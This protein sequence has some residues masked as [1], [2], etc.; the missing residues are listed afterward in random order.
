MKTWLNKQINNTIVN[1]IRSYFEKK[2]ALTQEQ[3]NLLL[4]DA[5]YENYLEAD[6]IITEQVDYQNKLYF[7]LRG[8]VLVKTYQPDG[9]FFCELYTKDEYFPETLEMQERFFGQHDAI[10][11]KDTVVLF[12]SLQKIN[13]L[14]TQNVQ[15]MNY[16][17]HSFVKKQM[18]LR[19]LEYACSRGKCNKRVSVVLDLF[20]KKCGYML[21]SGDILLPKALTHLVLESYCKSGHTII[22]LVLRDLRQKGFLKNDTQRLIL[23]GQML[24]K[25]RKSLSAQL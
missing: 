8:S 18:Q 25:F 1:E 13:K 10:A 20:A 24:T 5:Y 12:L 4:Q 21:P 19:D 2:L 6:S 11:C 22:C 15:V 17:Y 16:F 14:A 9:N 23:N 7:I 3:V